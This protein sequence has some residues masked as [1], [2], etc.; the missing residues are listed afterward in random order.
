[1]LGNARFKNTCLFK[2]LSAT[3]LPHS[4]SMF[5]SCCN[6]KPQL[7]ISTSIWPCVG[8]CNHKLLNSSSASSVSPC[9]TMSKFGSSDD[10]IYFDASDTNSS[11]FSANNYTIW[12]LL[13][14]IWSFHNVTYIFMHRK[15]MKRMRTRSMRY[16][17]KTALWIKFR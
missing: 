15:R 11:S 5:K 14:E 6:R 13:S 17:I 8:G 3:T 10:S 7:N 2:C 4:L 12:G 1:M 16:D 9:L